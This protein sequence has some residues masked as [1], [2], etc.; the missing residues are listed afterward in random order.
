MNEMSIPALPCMCANLRRAS[1]AITHLYEDALRPTGLRATQFSILQALTLAGDIT[2]GQLGYILATDSTTLTRTL[3]IMSR[4][5]WLKKRRGADGRE[6]RIGLAP[7]GKAIFQR[8]LPLWES[9]QAQLRDQLGDVQWKQ[10]TTLTYNLTKT[11]T[12][13]GDPL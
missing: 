1:R 9:V 5:G 4:H 8:A 3:G 13:Q 6:W 12:Q 11:A 10:L 7:K 2:Q